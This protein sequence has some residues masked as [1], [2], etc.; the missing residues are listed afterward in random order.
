MRTVEYNGKK[1]NIE[2]VDINGAIAPEKVFF[3]NDVPF[4][5]VYVEGSGSTKSQWVGKYIT[6]QEQW[7]AIT[8]KNP[9]HFKGKTRPVE[10]ITWL[11][12][13]DYINVLSKIVFGA[14]DVYTIHYDEKNEVKGFTYNYE[15]KEEPHFKLPT[16]EE[17]VWA[18]KGGK[19]SKGYEFAGSNDLKEVGW[20]SDN[21]NN[22]THPVGQLKH[23]ELNIADFSGN[24]WEYTMSVDEE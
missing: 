2:E 4:T 18:A 24:V 10:S 5:F 9:S 13:V 8:G 17:W 6:T 16:S 19:F 1:F 7:Y 12:T 21:S 11:E 15:G 20:Y 14:Q 23:N 22:E 3:I